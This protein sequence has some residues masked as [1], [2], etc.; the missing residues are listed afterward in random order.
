MKRVLLLLAVLVTAAP[1]GAQSIPGCGSAAPK[2]DIWQAPNF[3]RTIHGYTQTTRNIDGCLVKLRV[4]AWVEGIG[5]RAM[6]AESWS[7][8][9]SVSYSVPVPDYQSRTA[10]GKHWAILLGTSWVWLGF[11]SDTTPVLPPPPPPTYEPPPPDECASDEVWDSDVQ[12]CIP[13]SCPV[14]I[15]AGRN[16][17]RLTSAA[18]GVRFDL[19]A[20]GI[21]EQIA[22][23]HQDSDEAFLAMDRNG[24]GRIDDGSE[25]FG[26]H[27]PAYPGIRDVK[28]ANGFE[29]LGFLESPDYGRSYPDE[30]VDERDEV[31]GRL[32]LWTDRNHNGISEPEELQSASTAIKGISTQFKLVGRKD[33]HGNIFK[34]KGTVVFADGEEPVYDIWL[35]TER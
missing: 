23:T 1:A 21:P 31:F 14:I 19:D 27:T 29:A 24:N 9:V 12:R 6:V 28:T 4:E 11:S 7:A 8:A 5:M 17:Y 2:T 32:L 26:N 18:D 34:Q 20:D 15:D 13:N 22:W 3:K 33:K 35:T 10:I 16:G 25:L 30:L